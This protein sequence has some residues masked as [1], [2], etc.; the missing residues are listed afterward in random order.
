M[1]DLTQKYLDGRYVKN[2][3]NSFPFPF[4]A[5]PFHFSCMYLHDN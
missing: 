4:A 5:P 1:V 2:S 3:G